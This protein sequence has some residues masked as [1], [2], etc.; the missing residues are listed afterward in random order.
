MFVSLPALAQ[1][2]ILQFEQQTIR[3]NQVDKVETRLHAFGRACHVVVDNKNNNGSELLAL[4]EQELH[5]L[6]DKFGSH[7][8]ESIT[9][10]INLSAGT[11]SV[12]PVDD[13]A[14]SLFRYVDALWNRSNHLFDPTTKILLDCYQTD[15][16][17]RASPAQLQGMV[18]LVGWQHLE[19]SEQG[20]HLAKKGMLLDLNTCICPYAADAVRKVL[21][22]N[23]ASHALIDLDRDIAS[24]G[25]QPDGANWLVGSRFPKG[26]RTAIARLKLNNKGYSIRGNY[27]EAS[28]INGERFGRGLSPV[29]GLPIVGMLSVAVIAESC[30]TASSAANVAR[31]KTEAAAITWLESLGLP[32]LAVDR[33]LVCHG[34]LAP[35][36]L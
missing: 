23:G 14:H 8:P 1:V 28:M 21:L 31:L 6:E 11:G 22:K 7:N 16:Q 9:S 36:A 34:P 33:N 4:A 10:R 26:A 5:R 15:G 17:L 30:L 35:S 18:Q 12:T 32:W 27:E 2:E 19:L 29:D 3:R 20:A 24:I 25:K 13:E